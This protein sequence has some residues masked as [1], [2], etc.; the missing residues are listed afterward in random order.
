MTYD[1]SGAFNLRSPQKDATSAAYSIGS[2][3]CASHAISLSALLYATVLITLFSHACATF[4]VCPD[5][6]DRIIAGSNLIPCPTQDIEESG[7]FIGF[8]TGGCSGKATSVWVFMTLLFSLPGGCL[9]VNPWPTLAVLGSTIVQVTD[10]PN[11]F[12]QWLLYRKAPS[13]V[14]AL[15]SYRWRPSTPHA[16]PPTASDTELSEQDV[17]PLDLPSFELTPP[18]E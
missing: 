18:A 7:D 13:V 14:S 12:V 8:T 2:R 5:D 15:E 4:E 6:D 11:A 3:T 9:A 17:D 1:V 16:D 10:G